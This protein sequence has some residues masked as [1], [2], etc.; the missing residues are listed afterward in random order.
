MPISLLK[1][2]PVFIQTKGIH[3]VAGPELDKEIPSGAPVPVVR[4]RCN[5]ADNIR[6]PRSLPPPPP[7]CPSLPSCL[8][9]S[10]SL[11]LGGWREPGWGCEGG[12]KIPMPTCRGKQESCILS[13]SSCGS[14]RK[15]LP[16][17]ALDW[18]H[19][20]FSCH[21]LPLPAAGRQ[22]SQKVRSKNRRCDAVQPQSRSSLW[23]S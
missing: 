17:L 23:R 12:Q 14:H 3:V 9:P 20:P 13:M 6:E 11:A 10:C 18:K 21:L 4:D 7:P 8:P 19:N 2:L 16:L 1:R 15:S 22:E 5:Y